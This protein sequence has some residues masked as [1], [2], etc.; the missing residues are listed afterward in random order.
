MFA[1]LS[2]RLT[3]TFKNLRGK[4]RLTESDVN[5]TIRDIRL[6]LLDA[7]VALPVVKRFTGAVR[8]RALG[9]EV[10]QALNPA[11]QVV[12][13]VQEELVAILGGQ[14]RTIRFAKQPPTV[15]MLAGLQGSGK[16]TFAGK[17]GTWLKGQGHAPL[18]VA[19]DL[20]RPNAVTQLEVVGE[21]AGVP[22][23][24]PE[25]GNMGGHDAV[26]DSGE[27]TRS[28]GDPVTVS[29]MGIEHARAKQY[30][31]VIVDTAGRLA[32]D[33]NLMQQA[34]D[35]RAAISPD[36]VLFVI[37]AMIGQAAV[38]TAQAFH[39]GVAFT[40]VVLS[41]LDGDARG[42][43]ALSVAEI[44]GEPI[45]FASTGEKVTD[46]EVFH[47]DRMASRILDMGDVLTLIEQ[48]ERAF[49]KREAD[50]MARKFLAEEDFTFEDFL[51]QMNAIKKMG[52][53]K[54]MLKMMPGMQ[55]MR[56]QLDA[57]DDREF[58]R[59]EAMV[60]S[61]TPFERTHPKQINGSRR[62]RIAKGSGVTVTEVNQLLERFGQAQK[63]MKSM[64]RGGGGGLPGM[65]GI[66]GT[67]K[68]GKQQQPQRKKSK[69][70]NP[71][72]RA[73]EERAAAEKAASGRAAS[74]ASAFGAPGANGAGA[75]DDAD[76]LAGFDPSNLP[77]GFEKFLGGGR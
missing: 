21:R 3:A 59:V 61:M 30:D 76:P 28:F 51:S 7:D 6:A 11:Q 67:G 56:D 33:A 63:M 1:S 39:E 65:P 10:S 23:F 22:V 35:I 17:L 68:R 38:E 77:K 9:A 52:S 48:A 14:T 26:L 46:F 18:L 53:L 66:P 74:A 40:G 75:G 60:R 4:G 19:A 16:T 25:R 64:A 31:V 58:D 2:D 34:S 42:G 45:M 5:A 43:A 13:I 55:G 71:A 20:Q 15:I 70:G 47:P 37:D 72:K 12:K 32:V 69:S 8:E 27:G 44:T 57:F 49:D 50:E 24:A 36:E 41:K 54:S 73:A 62:A 29:R